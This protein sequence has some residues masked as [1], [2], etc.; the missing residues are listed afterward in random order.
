MKDT[1]EIPW[2]EPKEEDLPKKDV[3][4]RRYVMPPRCA[5]A[6]DTYRDHWSGTDVLGS[7]TGN[8]IPQGYNLLG[9]EPPLPHVETPVQDADDL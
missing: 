6:V 1:I 2:Q 9:L 8:L 3:T 4:P 7:Y 5:D